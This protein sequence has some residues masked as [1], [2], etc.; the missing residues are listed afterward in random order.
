[1]VQ[2][3]PDDPATVTLTIWAS[4]GGNSNWRGDAAIPAAEALNRELEAER[5]PVRVAVEVVNDASSWS[6]YKRKFTLAAES[7]SA[8]DIINSGHSDVASWAATNY[9]V[10]LADSVAEI[11]GLHP[12]FDDVFPSLWE[13]MMWGGRV[14]AVP[15][16]TEARPMYYSLPLLR[17]LGWSEE[18][19]ASLPQ[20]I[21]NDEFTLN[22]LIGTAEEAVAAGVV[23][24]GY[25]YWHRPV[26]GGDFLQYYFSHGG[27]IYD[28]QR[29]QL[30]I[31]RGALERFYR[32]Q[33]RV[34]EAEITPDNYIGTDWR[35]WHDTVAVGEALFWNGG[36]WQWSGWAEEQLAEM[37][38]EAWLHE[39][40]GY[41]LQPAGEGGSSG[42]LSH[43]LVYMVTSE[44]ASGAKNQGLATR[45]LMHM[46]TASINTNH[47]I[48]S[49]H[50][51]IVR[52]QIDY[53][54]YRDNTFLSDV[55]Y[56][57][58]HNYFQPNHPMYGLWF[59]IVWEG[60][61]AAQQ[62]EKTPERAAADVVNQLEFELGD[63]L[64][65]R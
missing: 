1:M 16:D 51:G 14:W 17:E 59:D 32:F 54:D 23:E 61:V 21:M 31:D 57:L 40:V 65:V 33:R 18:E 12:N 27:E 10:P 39:N 8:P 60:M 63:A 20:R 41:A 58:D 36:I 6:D 64:I 56:M 55:T 45:L 53:P 29:D 48:Q 52:S 7:G 3:T 26:K 47:A 4:G 30:V 35:V 49:A 13:S 22:D 28:P 24:A 42:T 46:T 43:P 11:R 5:A 38:G 34:V 44:T 15:Q 2:G 37:G 62:G 25:G 9:V 19:I 50:L